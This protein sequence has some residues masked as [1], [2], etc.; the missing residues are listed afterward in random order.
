[1]EIKINN[2]LI[3]VKHFIE[4]WWPKNHPSS[5]FDHS[6]RREFDEEYL[7]LKYEHEKWTFRTD[8]TYTNRKVINEHKFLLAKIKHGF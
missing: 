7:G 8:I 5:G 1:M 4:Y 2:Y 6:I 3:Y